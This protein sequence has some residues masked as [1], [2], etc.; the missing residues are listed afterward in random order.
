MRVKVNY[1]YPD[2]KPEYKF[3]G[4]PS[5]RL[6]AHVLTRVLPQRHVPGREK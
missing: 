6:P 1:D 2:V 4:I 5:S 3:F